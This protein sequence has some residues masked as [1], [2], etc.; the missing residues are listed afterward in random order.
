[1]LD[2]IHKSQRRLPPIAQANADRPI[3]LIARAQRDQDRHLLLARID[4]HK[5]PA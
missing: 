3:A 5:L 2:T 1:M 4:D